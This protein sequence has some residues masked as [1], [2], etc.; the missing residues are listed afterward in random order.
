MASSNAGF[1]DYQSFVPPP[2]EEPPRQ[3]GCFF[4]GCI[5]S[6]ILTLLLVIAVGVGFYFFYQFVGKMVDQYTA[7]APTELPRVEMPEEERK[8]VAERVKAFREALKEGTPA[9]PLV[10]TSE[11]I[12]AAIE[13]DAD[14]KGK[15]YVTIEK[16]KLKGQVSIPLTDFPSF[17]LTR[18]RYLNGQA[19]FNVWVKDGVLFVTISSLEINGKPAPDEF[20]NSFRGQNLAKDAHTNPKYG[21]AIRNLE[22]VEIKDGKL[23]ITPRRRR[24]WRTRSGPGIRPAPRPAAKDPAC[25]R[26]K[27]RRGRHGRTS[28]R[29]RPSRPRSLEFFPGMIPF[30]SVAAVPLRGNP[31]SVDSSER[32]H[33]ED[34]IPPTPIGLAPGIGPG[35]A[36]RRVG[37][38]R[39]PGEG[40]ERWRGSPSTGSTTACACCCSPIRPDP[41]SRST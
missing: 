20:F 24:D 18:G 33:D 28:P 31:I 37:L 14:L 34:E 41:R 32:H 38:R 7:T 13:Q 12:N 8:T 15:V 4:W 22:N 6:I 30:R 5:I 16:D 9:E 3:H 29:R 1:S 35:P 2:Y 11:E 23:I 19:E 39:R 26:R 10:L 27:R 25:A 17:G 40:H 21:Q 36:R